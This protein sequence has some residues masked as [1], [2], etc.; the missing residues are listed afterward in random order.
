MSKVLFPHE[1]MRP[2][3]KEIVKLISERVEKGEDVIMHAP[4][5]LGKTAASIAPTLIHALDNRKTI[6]L[7]M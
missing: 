3:Q 4:T 5:G 7:I 2:I 6:Y 1:T